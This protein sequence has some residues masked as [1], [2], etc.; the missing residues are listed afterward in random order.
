MTPKRLYNFVSKGEAVTWGILLTGLIL[1]SFGVNPMVVTIG[2]S[3][4]GAMF[5][6][7]AVI[8]TLVGVNQRWKPSR[9]VAAV[10]LAIVPFATVP[11]EKSLEKKSLL[12]GNWRTL[13]NENPKDAGWF[14]SLFVWFIARPLLLIITL[15]VAGSIIFAALLWLGSPTRWGEG[16]A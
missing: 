16:F 4:H 14:D 12:E 7:Y 5:L 6:S 9:T 8:A 10:A 3:I 15:A 11:F 2:G 13:R 1:R